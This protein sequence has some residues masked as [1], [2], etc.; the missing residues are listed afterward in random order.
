E[1]KQADEERKRTEDALRKRELQLAHAQRVARIGSWEWDIGE[2]QVAWSDELYRIFG[3]SPDR[4]G[5]T[6]EAVLEVVH[7]DDKDSFDATIRD[8]LERCAAFES[9]HRIIRSDGATRIL[10]CH[11]EV[12]TD[13]A[14]TP[15]RM[16]GTCQDV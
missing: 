7:P 12:L 9:E 6:F 4:F 5:A 14:L 15:I 16:V 10:Q 11:G 1:R 3:L 8:A 2:N 13:A